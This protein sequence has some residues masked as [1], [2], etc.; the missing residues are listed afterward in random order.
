MINNRPF[1]L[2]GLWLLIF[3]A[4][5]NASAGDSPRSKA[6]AA[7]RGPQTRFAQPQYG[8]LDARRQQIAVT[9]QTLSANRNPV[10]AMSSNLS[11]AAT[12]TGFLTGPQISSGGA[13]FSV[14]AGDFN[15]DGKQDVAAIVFDTSSN[16]S[17]SILLGQGDGSFQPPI[18][19]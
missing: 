13:P 19:T 2:A 1:F 14:V 11:L 9:P 4:T 3:G 17:L 5:L 15:G 8:P 18:L 6:Q 16:Y 12:G 7:Q 10:Q